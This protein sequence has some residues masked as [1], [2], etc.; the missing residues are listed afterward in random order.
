MFDIAD[1]VRIKDKDIYGYVVEVF[2]SPPGYLI[3]A[4]ED[5]EI[6]DCYAD[7]VEKA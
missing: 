4:D 2:H 5:N 7:E 1:R 6:Y 3:E